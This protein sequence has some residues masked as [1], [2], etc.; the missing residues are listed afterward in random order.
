MTTGLIQHAFTRVD[1][2][3]RQLTGRCAGG[4]ITR[5]LLMSRGVG[6]DKFALFGREVTISDINGN[7]LLTLSL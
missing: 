6:D 7:A 2:Q 1:Q 4:H 3:D 5:V